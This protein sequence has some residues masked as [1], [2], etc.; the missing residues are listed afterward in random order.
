MLVNIAYH[1]KRIPNFFNKIENIL[2]IFEDSLKKYSNYEIFQIFS[3]NKRILLFLIKEKLLVIDD[4]IS[5]IMISDKYIERQYHTFFYPEIEAILKKGPDEIK[6]ERYDSCNL[7]IQYNILNNTRKLC[8]NEENIENGKD[9]SEEEENDNEMTL[10]EE[11]EENM[12]N[13]KN[14]K[15]GPIEKF[16]EN[17]NIGENEDN[18]CKLILK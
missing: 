10:Y 6:Q 4:H 2:K 8:F 16:E 5:H 13:E 1:H 12:F 15:K 18:I 17:R 7:P 3:S 9:E 14:I 11:E